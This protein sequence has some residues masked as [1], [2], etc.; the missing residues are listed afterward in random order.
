MKSITRITLVLLFVVF[1]IA[2]I[3]QPPAGKATPGTIYGAKTNNS[4][5]VEASKI[6]D[7]LKSKD[8]ISVKVKAKVLDACAAKGCWMT[9]KIND[10][11]E[12]MVKM[13]DYGFFVPQDIIGKTVVVD[14]KSYIKTISVSELK[15]YAEDANKPQKEI[16]AI[17]QPEKQVRFMANG[18]LVVE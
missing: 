1:T 4:N 3:A 5:T 9:L 6:P 18:I 16:D 12:A 17:T 11:T 7:M 10:S 14:G 13:K 8:T 15:H 2:G